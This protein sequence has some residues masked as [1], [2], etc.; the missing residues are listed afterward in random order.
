MKNL[1]LGLALLSGTSAFAASE[2]SLKPGTHIALQALEDTVV[3][4]E[5]PAADA[6]VLPWCTI[7]IADGD[8]HVYVGETQA[9]SWGGVS[10]SI[11]KSAGDL[12]ASYR[13]N[14]ICR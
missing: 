1:K 9:G 13:E 6:P 7:R 12:A 11:A 4:C 14:G 2:I 3:R 5:A 8:T 10:S